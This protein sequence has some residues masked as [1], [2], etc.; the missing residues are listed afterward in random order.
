M[1]IGWFEVGEF[2]SQQTNIQID[3]KFWKTERALN[4]NL[5]NLTE[6]LNVGLQ[7]HPFDDFFFYNCIYLPNA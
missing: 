5:S 4:K 7:N 1:Y 2:I 6:H 3:Y